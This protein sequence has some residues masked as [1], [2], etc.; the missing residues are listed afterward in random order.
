MKMY[1]LPELGYGYDALEPHISEDQL[2]VHHDK[3]HKAYVDGANRLLEKLD[4]A[5]KG[6]E[7][8]D[9]KALLKELSWQVG[10]HVLHSLYWENMKP[11][12]AGPDDNVRSAID[13]DFGSMENF[14][15]EFS[16]AAKSIEGSGWAC[17]AYCSK[18]DRLLTMQIEKHNMNIYPTFGL[19]L[20]MD[21]FEHAYYIDHW[22]E[23]AKYV[24][25]FREIIDWQAVA[26]RLKALE[27]DGGG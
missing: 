4:K 15:K 9:T 19:L 21:M 22:N 3:H 5:H 12:G 17:L 24:D 27:K 16:S 18:T 26:R 10:G 14:W 25:A 6:K 1:E 2:K 23:K 11:G 8:L 7:E 13:K 20:V